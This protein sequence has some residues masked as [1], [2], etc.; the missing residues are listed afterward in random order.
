MVCAVI[1]FDPIRPYRDD[2]VPAVLRR[3]GRDAAMIGDFARFA[4]PSLIRWLPPIARWQVGNKLRAALAEV[5]TVDAF[6]GQLAIL[7]ERMIETTTDGFT[8]TGM[9]RLDPICN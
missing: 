2:E 9:Q 1:E 5:E 8:V 6:Q 4:T 7:F 3:L